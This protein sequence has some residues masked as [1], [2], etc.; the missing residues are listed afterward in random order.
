ML[1]GRDRIVGGRR[2]G[3]PRRAKASGLSLGP[4]PALRRRS[5]PWVRWLVLAVALAVAGV[6]FFYFEL[7]R[8]RSD[9]MAPTLLAGDVALVAK[10]DPPHLGALVLITVG[11]REVVRRV[12]G[13][14][15]D[16]LAAVEGVL[17][18]NG[19]PLETHVRGLFSYQQAQA[20]A[21]PQ[22]SALPAEGGSAG[23]RW[24]RQSW[25]R[26]SLG[27]Q[28]SYEVLGDYAGTAVPWVQAF[29]PLAVPRGYLFLLCDNRP[30]CDFDETVG[31]VPISAVR[32]ILRSVFWYGDGREPQQGVKPGYG[33]LRSLSPA[34]QH[35]DR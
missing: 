31:P 3:R 22:A 25:L 10:R 6:R 15:G 1:S 28:L 32:G 12:V 23:Q 11:D 5:L 7:V 19:F 18:R 35:L 21:A 8:L 33:G 20:A 13:L 34:P 17:V 9:T 24:V 4:A 16:E 29:E 30:T 26:E 27:P 14:P 2:R